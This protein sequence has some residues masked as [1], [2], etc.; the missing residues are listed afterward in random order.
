MSGLTLIE[1]EVQNQHVRWCVVKLKV[2]HRMLGWW[3]GWCGRCV[4]GMNASDEGALFMLTNV[5]S[6]FGTR[7]NARKCQILKNW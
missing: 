1:H 3:S 2:L 6:Y 4:P 5:L 7:I